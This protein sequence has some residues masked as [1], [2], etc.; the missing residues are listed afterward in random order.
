MTTLLLTT[1]LCAA[2]PDGPRAELVEVRKIWD[3]APHNAFT[4]LVRFRDRWL[5]VFRE[6]RAHVSP[7]GAIRIIASDDGQGWTNAARLDHNHAD[8]R[9]PK[10]TTTSDGR[11]MLTYAGAM[12]PPSATKH[13]TFAR[14]STDGKEWTAPFEIG[15]PDLWLWRIAWHNDMA[16][17]LGYTTDDR[18]F[19][20]L[21][22]SRDGIQFKTLVDRLVDEGYPNESSLVFLPDQTAL[23]LLRRDEGTAT[24]LLGSARPPYREW[25]WDDL[26]QRIGGPRMI[27]L[28]DGRLVA[29]V[30]LHTPK[31]HT[32]L[33]W[34]D[35]Q[36][37]TLT[38]FLPLP[39]GGDTS[40]PGL[41]WHDGLLWVSYY[42]SHEGKTSIYLAKVKLP[43]P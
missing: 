32:G 17:G 34:I 35:P 1:L 13:I 2:P 9:D 41:A 37:G 25:T 21:Y 40:Y 30:R 28:D 18:K 11:L 15:Q 5:C 4:D 14:F 39:S 8:L 7:D 19:V 38:E 29:G 24:G 33:A 31:V 6:G 16:Y 20:R 42:S 27:R 12:H 10:I 3:H 43:S 23:C 22:R 36:A 26:G